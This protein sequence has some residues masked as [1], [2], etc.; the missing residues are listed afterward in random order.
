M[1]PANTELAITD[2]EC[3]EVF[4]EEMGCDMSQEGWKD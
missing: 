3:R 1:Q 2:A 4:W